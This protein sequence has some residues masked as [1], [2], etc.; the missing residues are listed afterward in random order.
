MRQSD[1]G[2]PYQ[3]PTRL[4][5]RL[6]GLEDHIYEGWPSFDEGSHYLGPLPKFTGTAT[7][8]IGRTGSGFRTADTAAW[9][10]KLCDLLAK[11][12]IAA[13][14]RPTQA[15][16]LAKGAELEGDAERGSKRALPCISNPVE[17]PGHRAGLR[18]S[19]TCTFAAIRGA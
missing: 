17:P 8:L 7:R 11:L 16:A 1:F 18:V 6:P 19:L 14:R 2:T 5:G 4:L 15:G 9:P 12:A 10:E 3:K 13:I